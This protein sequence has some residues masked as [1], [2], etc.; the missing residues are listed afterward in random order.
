MERA[1]EYYLSIP[2][3]KTRK[4][5]F[6]SSRKYPAGIPISKLS[7]LNNFDICGIHGYNSEYMYTGDGLKKDKKI[8]TG[9]KSVHDALRKI[10]SGRCDLLLTSI[11]PVYGAAQIGKYNI[12]KYI[13]VI[14]MSEMEP[15]T[16]HI[17]ISRSSPRA[18]ELLT[19]IN[20]AILILQHNGVSKEIFKKYLP[21]L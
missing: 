11:E 4:G 21:E 20:Q 16:F 9:A 5:V 12:P 7:D 19:K 15:T 17:F 6:Y 2:I 3:Y 14:P 8:D 18:Y 1:E 13:S 10:A